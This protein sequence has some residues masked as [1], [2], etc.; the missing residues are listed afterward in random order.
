MA[1]MR[2]SVPQRAGRRAR[3][4]RA[5]LLV[6]VPLVA[7]V[8]APAA[9]AG[10][11]AV[12]LGGA[13]GFGVLGGST[14]TNTG[15]S[16]IDGDLGL[17]PGTSVTGFPPGRA[18]GTMHVRDADAR[19]AKSDLAAAYD[20]AAGR[21]SSATLP[22]DL[23]GR[24]RTAGVYRTGSV[25]SLGLTGNLTLDARGDPRAV[26]I[27]QIKST[28][29]TATDSSVRLINGAQ[30]CNVYWQV[31]GSA[32]LGTR[33]AF[34]GNVLALT[35]ISVNDG[36]TVSGRLL[37]RNGAVTMRNDAVTR[38]GCAAGTGPTSGIGPAT[39]PISGGMDRRGPLV[40]IAGIP[41][42][43]TSQAR[44]PVARPAVCARR[45]FTARVRVRD[46]SGIR[47][48]KVYLNAKLIR[49]STRKR[50]SVHVSVR[51]LRVGGNRI[52]VL[53]R[54]RARNLSATRRRF[55]RCAS[56]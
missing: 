15:P 51:R 20:D 45:G 24:T 27:F 35:S 16:I 42:A 36:V 22:P 3:A 56:R 12:L 43:Y 50:F 55:Q 17:Y 49:R 41:G 37:A 52:T 30:A 33:T 47:R 19:W 6:L 10:E 25:A 2:T 8:L 18:N 54:D 48:V 1:M 23:G 53:A 13:E 26:F 34:K 38:S 32:A 29:T 31:G 39:S 14:I 46:H 7:L 5:G 21:P 28:L 11:P 9:Q 4:C 40:R 44:R